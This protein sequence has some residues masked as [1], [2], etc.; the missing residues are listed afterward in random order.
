M[1]ARSFGVFLFL[2]VFPVG[3][4]SGTCRKLVAVSQR[5]LRDSK[6]QRLVGAIDVGSLSLRRTSPFNAVSLAF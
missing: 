3:N 1:I 5:A 4:I 6:K 2:R